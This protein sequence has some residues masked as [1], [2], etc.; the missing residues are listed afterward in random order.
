VSIVS[1]ALFVVAI[2]VALRW[3]VTRL[4]WR[5]STR[6]CADQDRCLKSRVD[7]KGHSKSGTVRV[8]RLTDDGEFADRCDLAD[9]LYE[10]RNPDQPELVVWYVHGWKHSG[11]E[12]DS[13]LQKFESLIAALSAKQAEAGPERRHVVGVYIAWDGAVGP[14]FL[15]NLTFWNRKRAADRIS[16]SAV[17]TKIIAMT[18]Y[19]R[20]QAEDERAKQKLVPEGNGSRDLTVM[21]GHSFGAR[22]LYTATSQV[23]LYEVES[24]HPG[25]VKGAYGRIKGPADLILLVNPAFE[26]SIY[27]AMDTVRRSEPWERINPAQQP[28][29]LTV[30]T[31][32]DWAT[33][34]AFP[35]GQCL[36]FARMKRQR[37]T[38]GNYKKYVTHTLKRTGPRTHGGPARDTFWFDDFETDGLL[39]EQTDRKHPGNPF[40][41]AATTKDI[42]NGHNGIWTEGFRNWLIGFVVALEQHAE[43][44]Q[45]HLSAGQDA[46][47]SL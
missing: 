47:L 4:L 42:I 46:A 35:L 11:K 1:T 14:A 31:R 40:V 22:I 9:V 39:L 27:T 33:R 8:I 28:L 43:G 41:V 45:R 23:L 38:I 24:Q 16:Q 30:S 29:M 37:R 26:A 12:H 15:Q 36:E 13:D 19:A 44:R 2:Y 18:R 32:N 34:I 20:R 3:F 6:P 7:K 25:F 21:I 5:P 17:L 10:I